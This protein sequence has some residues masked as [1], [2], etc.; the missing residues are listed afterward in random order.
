M[1]APAPRL[2][3]AVAGHLQRARKALV[4]G[5]YAQ[6]IQACEA[7]L[8]FSPKNPDALSLCGQAHLKLG[9]ID[10]AIACLKKRLELDPG[11]AQVADDIATLLM[12]GR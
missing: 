11:N 9:Q 7:V 6:C 10:S 4:Q 8:R 2:S 1:A 3:P 5:Q 12:H